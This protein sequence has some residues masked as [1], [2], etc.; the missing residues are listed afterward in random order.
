MVDIES[1]VNA[2]A[3][4]AGVERSVLLSPLR[5]WPLPVARA[6]AYEY[7]WDLKMSDSQIGKVFNRNHSTVW[8][9]KKKLREL[10]KYDKEVKR[11]YRDFTMRIY[12]DELD[13]WF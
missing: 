10:L 3:V 1:A 7:L 5:K 2:S 11:M 9:Y 13:R 12:E 4:V 6:M 8:I